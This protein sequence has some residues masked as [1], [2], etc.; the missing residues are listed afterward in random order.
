MTM[1]RSILVAACLFAASAA[2]AET[3]STT[4]ATDTTTATV[5]TTDTTTATATT[6]DTT[7]ATTTPTVKWRPDYTVYGPLPGHPLTEPPAQV[8]PTRADLTATADRLQQQLDQLL[9]GPQTAEAVQQEEILTRRI[10]TIQ[11][12]IATL[13]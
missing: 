5:T 11:D 3:L 9:N 6:T 8:T 12:Q 4:T 10:S 13:P 2:S 7:T 1:T